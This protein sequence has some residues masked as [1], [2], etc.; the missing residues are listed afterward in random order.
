MMIMIMMIMLIMMMMVTMAMMI[1][2]S[3]TMRDM[4]SDCCQLSNRVDESQ[5]PAASSRVHVI[6]TYFS[7]VNICNKKNA[8]YIS[9]A[10]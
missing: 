3:T 4:C 9:I 10:Q 2:R 8:F 6:C 5:V 7:F 1:M